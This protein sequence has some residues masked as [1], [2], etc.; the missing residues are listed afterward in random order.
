MDLLP[1]TFLRY[2]VGLHSIREP[3]GWEHVTS[4]SMMRNDNYGIVE[5]RIIEH[6]S[7]DRNSLHWVECGVMKKGNDWLVFR[8]DLGPRKFA[9]EYA[10]I[11]F[12]DV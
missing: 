10:C 9:C 2:R 7:R 1:F 5:G 12:S 11:N 8:L 6:R 3:T 4:S